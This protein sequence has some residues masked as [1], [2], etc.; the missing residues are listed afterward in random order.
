MRPY[1]LF[2]WVNLNSTQSLEVCSYLLAATRLSDADPALS[3]YVAPRLD[4]QSW[5]RTRIH[6]EGPILSHKQSACLSESVAM[7]VTEAPESSDLGI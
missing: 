6:W 3:F 5:Y 4:V 7:E 1:V 2:P